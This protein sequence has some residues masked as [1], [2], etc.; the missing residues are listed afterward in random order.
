ML[1]KKPVTFIIAEDDE[2]DQLLIKEAL[3]ACAVRNPV[4]FVNDGVELLELLEKSTDPKN[5][6][7][8]NI[9]PCIILLDLNMPRMDGREALQKIKADPH[10]KHIPVVILTTSKTQED[11][12]RSYATGVN[13]FITKPVAFEGLIKV[14]KQFQKYWVEVVALPDTD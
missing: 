10:L 2:D 9:K 8:P 7:T 11:I 3:E 12:I 6:D 5:E 13:S 14:I 1:N 4:I